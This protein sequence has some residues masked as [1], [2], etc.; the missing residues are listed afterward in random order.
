VPESGDSRG[1]LSPHE[2]SHF[3]MLRDSRSRAWPG[4]TAE[5]GCPHMSTLIEG[6]TAGGGCPHMSTLASGALLLRFWAGGL[7][8][9]RGV[10]VFEVLG[11]TVAQIFCGFIVGGLVGPGVAG[12]ENF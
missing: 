6:R 2:H 10:E 5:G 3:K 8:F 11:E 9:G 4:R 12:P 7:Y 1:R